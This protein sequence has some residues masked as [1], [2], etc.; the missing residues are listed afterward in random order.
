MNF[1]FLVK[2]LSTHLT[3]ISFV[4][5]TLKVFSLYVNTFS[6]PCG[7]SVYVRANS[8]QHALI[9]PPTQS[10]L[11]L[12]HAFPVGGFIKCCVGYNNQSHIQQEPIID[13]LVVSLN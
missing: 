13:G 5:C 12:H 1:G 6:L 8:E 4:Y 9:K 10:L 7:R 3:G 2:T 11:G